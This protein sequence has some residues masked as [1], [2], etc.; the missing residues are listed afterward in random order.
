[1]VDSNGHSFSRDGGQPDPTNLLL[2][3][4]VEAWGKGL[5]AWQALAGMGDAGLSDPG[6]GLAATTAPIEAMAKAFDSARQQGAGEADSQA[7]GMSPALAKAWMAGAASAVRYWSALAEL[8]IRYQASLVHAAAD[9]AT[10][11]SAAS[12]A[13]QRLHA[14]E[15]RAFLRGV[16]DATSQEAR[17]LQQNL[18]RIGEAIAEAV[19]RGTPSPYPAQHRR[20][21]ELKL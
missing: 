3:G 20:R 16:G 4:V 2:G 7:A 19:D 14:D 1:M 6:A 5:A 18:E 15:L 12:P 10:G 13:Q 11:Q 8:G 21:H 17:L 9:R